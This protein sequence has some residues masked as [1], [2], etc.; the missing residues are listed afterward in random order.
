MSAHDSP[1]AETPVPPQGPRYFSS[2][3]LAS[4]LDPCTAFEELQ[5]QGN[6]YVAP[7]AAPLLVQ[8]PPLTL[9]SPLEDEDGSPLPHAHLGLPKAVEHFAR[10]A[11]RAVLEAALTNKAAWFRRPIE[12]ASLRASFK[13]FCREG[14]LKVRVP[15]DALVFDSGGT[16]VTRESVAVGSSARCLLELSKVCFGR[17]EFGAMWTLVQAQLAAAPP[18]PPR[19]MIDP[20]VEAAAPAAG[21]QAEDADQDVHEFL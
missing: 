5:K 6:L 2:V 11:E 4:A 20:G 7:L 8:T 17:T 12:D 14:H 1:D 19:C 3:D 16:L 21:I 15:R 10:A 18:P 13:Q 9:G